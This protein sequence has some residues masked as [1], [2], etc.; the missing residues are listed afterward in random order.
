MFTISWV[1]PLPGTGSSPQHM[2]SRPFEHGSAVPMY[3]SLLG[4]LLHF[5]NEAIFEVWLYCFPL[6]LP[7]TP[8][9]LVC[10]FGWVAWCQ[11]CLYLVL[12]QDCLDSIWAVPVLGDSSLAHHSVASSFLGCDPRMFTALATGRSVVAS[13]GIPRMVPGPCMWLHLPPLLLLS[14]LWATGGSSWGFIAVKGF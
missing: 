7:P 4:T 13:C 8:H 6:F 10:S 9:P 2:L 3:N 1:S 11:Y 14:L 12:E 5:Y